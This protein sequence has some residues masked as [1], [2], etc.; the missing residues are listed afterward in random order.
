MERGEKQLL[1]ETWYRQYA[2]LIFHYAR[3][4]EDRYGAE[5]VVQETFRIAWEALQKAEITYPKTWLRKTAENVMRNR[6]REREKRR[7]L[8]AG[9]E[10]LP[11]EKQSEDPVN[12]ELEYGGLID[13]KDLYLLRLLAVDGDT[14]A[15]AA[16]KLNTT[17]E[18]C[19]K[20]AKR[21]QK[22]LRELLCE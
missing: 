20:R 22:K 1:M 4:F 2:A 10:D 21:A 5:E 17:A 14:Y 18:A 6:L 15:E 16:R 19:R 12:V 9:M 3:Q 13:P 11:E 7:R 8:Q